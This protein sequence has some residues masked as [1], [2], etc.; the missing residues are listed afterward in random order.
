VSLTVNTNVGALSTFRNLSVTDGRMTGSLEKLSSGL[1]INRAADDAA[2]LA[3]SE[4]L[5]A[6]IGGAR[7][8]LRNAQ[9]GIAVAQTAEGALA[10]THDILHRM[11]DLSVQAANSG[12]LTDD[13]RGLLQTEISAL[14]AEVDRIARTTTWNG[15]KLLDGGFT[16]S[17]Q[18]GA[19]RGDSIA[20]SLPRAM[21]TTGLGLAGAD[22]SGNGRYR[23]EPGIGTPGP[24]EVR[25]RTHPFNNNGS[26]VLNVADPDGLAFDGAQAAEAFQRLDGIIDFDGHTFDLSSVVYDLGADTDGNG[27]VD[28]DDL[29][30]QL[31]DAAGQ[32]FGTVAPTF[33][34]SSGVLAFW[35][36]ASEPAYPW[37]PVTA[38]A[39][40]ADV[41]RATPTF[42]GGGATATLRRI[43]AAIG[44]VSET[45]GTL[46]A[47]QNR[48]ES[49]V[50]SLGVSVE[51]L[52]ASES[53][54]RDTDMA[55]EMAGFTRNQVLSQAGT[56]MLA[57][58]GQAAKGVLALL[59]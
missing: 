22:V 38:G 34:A 7:V 23:F 47:L 52:T 37:L 10:E 18:V 40:A 58:A 21:G 31:N 16:T 24:G 12:G 3:I 4:G 45:R 33:L 30:A 8:A 39:S 53:R 9:D 55:V 44:A 41:S 19:N 29:L 15:T 5:R 54:I 51:N 48:L 46:G 20:V 32:A 49:T 6:Q 42:R 59:N 28:P 50:R 17:F 43:D 2:G 14:E 25:L 13:A 11:R 57:Q 36:S 1:R 35:V 27:T 26:G 56:A